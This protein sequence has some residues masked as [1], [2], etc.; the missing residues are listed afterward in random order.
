MTFNIAVH[1]SILPFGQAP[2]SEYLF[3]GLTEIF[4]N[5][6]DLKQEIKKVTAKKLK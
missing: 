1:I 2:S 6:T 4:C 5:S 3:D